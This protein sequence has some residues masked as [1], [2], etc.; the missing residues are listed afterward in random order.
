LQA[1]SLTAQL[2]A[3]MQKF[4]EQQDLARDQWN[5]SNAQAVEQSNM[6]WRRQANLANT[7]AQNSANQQNAQ[8]AF[9]LTSQEQTQ[10]WQQLR[11]EAAYIRQAYENDNQRKAQLL[12]TALSNSDT[13]VGDFEDIIDLDW[14]GQEA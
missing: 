7:A 11:D 10:L 1:A 4:N 3:D 5:A 6:Q 9:N 13:K 2:D 14:N 12:A 8:I